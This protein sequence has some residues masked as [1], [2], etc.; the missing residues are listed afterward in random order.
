MVAV[1]QKQLT[2][3]DIKGR[4]LEL[5]AD[6]VGI[7]DGQAMN[8][9]PP[10]P[11]DPRRPSDITDYDADRVIVIGQRVSL[12]ATR[13]LDWSDRH[14]YVND[15]LV[16]AGLEEIALDLVRWLEQAGYPALIVPPTH[17]DPWRYDGDPHLH[18][19]LPLSLDHAAVEA[20]LG[21]LGL[22]LQ[23]LTPEYG[24]R[25]I[26]AAVLSSVP[27]T[28]DAPR[29]D[30]LC[31][32]PECGRCLSACPGDAVGQWSRDWVACDTYRQ[33]HGF[34]QV[35]EFMDEMID[36]A[37]PE[38]QKKMLR[39]EKSFHIWTSILRGAGAV[40]GCRRCQDVCPVGEDYET[41]LRDALDKIPEDSAEKQARLAD[42]RKA[43]TSGARGPSHAQQ[44]RWIGS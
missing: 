36:E 39:N 11:D 10:D 5:G 7:A 3:E 43:E 44:R 29:K 9:N 42:M 27:V 23:L 21:T 16:I 13:I 30:A 35:A 26:L 25:V 33:P 22:N 31:L 18:Q 15:E 20:G 40:T 37:D 14:K 6:I 34:K 19:K 38:A 4:A 28:P 24:P 41:M 12:G 32:G 1:Y 2:A 17:V 8:D